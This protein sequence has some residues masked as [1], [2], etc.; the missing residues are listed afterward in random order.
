MAAMDE[1][2]ILASA[3]PA[4]ARL[5]AAAGLDFR[6]EAAAVDEEAVRCA[7]R[8]EGAEA[9]EC[10]LALAELKAR[11]ISERY[12]GALVVGADQILVCDGLWFD[13][14]AGM[15]E[16]RA[17]LQALRGKPHALATAVCAVLLTMR[18]FSDAFLD[19]YLAAEGSAILG[20]V[21]AYRIEGRG[22]QLFADIDGDYFAVL[23]LPLLPLLA[24]LRERGALRQ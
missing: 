19:A 15:A 18:A 16:A 22:I 1:E 7:Y 4:R 24:F 14:P 2:L 5:L 9:A 12:P 6:V 23:G 3:S 10:A 8:A 17:Q 11:R 21:G 20:S 13:K